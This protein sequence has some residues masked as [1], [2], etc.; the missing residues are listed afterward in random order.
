[1]VTSIDDLL[2]WLLSQAAVHS[3][4]VLHQRLGDTGFTGYEYRILS[5]LADGEPLSQTELGQRAALDRS[6]VTA[7]VRKLRVRGLVDGQADPNHGRRVII[8]LTTAGTRAWTITEQVMQGVQD[9]VFGSLSKPEREA[10]RS[11]LTK[12]VG[13]PAA[14]NPG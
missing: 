3:H 14:P 1:M 4:R 12:V 6:D 9:E 8:T 13:R 2:T 7:S 11:L 10:L 5:A